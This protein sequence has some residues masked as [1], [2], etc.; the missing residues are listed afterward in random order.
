MTVCFRD[1]M[2]LATVWPHFATVLSCCSLCISH[3]SH[4]NVTNNM[5]I[6]NKFYLADGK[7]MTFFDFAGLGG[8]ARLGVLG[9]VKGVGERE[10]EKPQNI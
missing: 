3:F 9:G 8:L 2:C 5:L 1:R 6:V 7:M 10:E 4:W